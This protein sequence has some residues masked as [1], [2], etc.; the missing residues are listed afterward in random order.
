ML[1]TQLRDILFTATWYLIASSGPA[2]LSSRVPYPAH[3]NLKD[4]RV[5]K[6]LAFLKICKEE[7]THLK[8]VKM[9]LN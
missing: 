8:S 1:V 2:H 6:D 3:L 5:P 4:N 9:Q 7:A